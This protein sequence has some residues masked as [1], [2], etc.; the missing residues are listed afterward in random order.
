MTRIAV[1]NAEKCNPGKC[2]NLCVK[3]CPVNR[4]GDEC[5]KI[6]DETGKAVIEE[7]LCTGCGICQNRCPFEAIHII[8]LPKELDQQEIHRYG[9]NGFHLYNLPTPLFGKV[10]GIIGR[11]GIGKSTALGI[12]AGLIKPNL[13]N[14]KEA[15][16]EDL[17]DFFKGTEAQIF[18]ERLK[19]GTI[20]PSFKPQQVD[21]IPKYVKGNVK[22]ILLS[23]SSEDK[24]NE[25]INKL[26]IDRLLD[27]DI[28][29]L[30]GGELQLVAIAIASTKPAN[31]FFFD[32]P[33]SY[34]DIKQ[35]L[36]AS[37]FIRGLV[38]DKDTSVI[39]VEHDLIILD[40]MSDMIH[41]LYGKPAVYGI[42]S[43]PKSTKEGI[44][45]YLQG[46]LKQEN[47]RFRDKPIKFHEKQPKDFKETEG[48][49]SWDNLTKKLGGFKIEAPE[50]LIRK[51]EIVGVVGENGIGKTTF[52]KML[53]DVLKPDSGVIK[54]DKDLKISYKPQYLQT[55]SDKLVVAVLSEA[56]RYESQII[57]PLNLKPLFEKPLNK[58]SGG[59]LQRVS[60]AV[61]LARDAEII[62]LDE[63]SAYL[64]VEQ[65]LIVSRVIRDFI[66]KE[67]RAALIVDHDLLFIDYISDSIMVFEGK[68]AKQGIAK[69]PF[70][71]AKG[72]NLFLRSISKT[73]RRDPENNR[74][75]INKEGSQLDQKQ[76]KED[77]FYYA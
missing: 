14:E 68:P 37:N 61:A 22:D 15:N 4:T 7:A 71:L 9:N 65:R 30:S 33:T 20:K 35:R 28:G 63:P 67:N 64:D 76:K 31:I 38:T 2:N 39:L 75:R 29:D 46:F 50:G 1:V 56:L 24:V 3:L 26:N 66:E 47:I 74:P 53:A 25:I 49:V 32:E 57:K 6:S 54:K 60:V 73:L 43:M 70:N 40:Y 16:Y 23:T 69:G 62:L 19:S 34:L 48:L 77:R 11:N 55:A 41:I 44:N 5:I 59:E 45:I 27:R 72:M 52:V 18:F 8:N 13:G 36:N 42:S 21:Q 51:K 10:V 58:L 17:I 12:L